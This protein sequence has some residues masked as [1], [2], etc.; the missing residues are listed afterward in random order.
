MSDD[1]I[2]RLRDMAQC[3]H[4]DLSAADEAADWIEHQRTKIDALS[5]QKNRLRE[6]IACALF[7]YEEGVKMDEDIVRMA[8]RLRRAKR[9]F[10]PAKGGNDNGK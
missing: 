8:G 9:E 5:A 4:D 3:K 1:L 2:Q 7:V 10:S 6:H